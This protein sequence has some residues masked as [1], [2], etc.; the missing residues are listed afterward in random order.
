LYRITLLTPDTRVTPD[1][2]VTPDAGVTPDTHVTPPDT[3]RTWGDI[4]GSSPLTR[5]SPKPPMNPKEPPYKLKLPLCPHDAIVELFHESLP[6]L[7]RVRLMEGKRKTAIK[8]FWTWVL[9]SRKSDGSRRAET[10]E[11]ALQWIRGYF[12]RTRSN[13]FLMGRTARSEAHSNW[14]CDLDYL[15][16]DR[17]RKQVIEKTEEVHS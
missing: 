17:G 6:E 2:C 14:K 13:D 16:T 7:P 3:Q 11:Q 9:Q 1:I 12:D 10:A 4:Q 15:L 5:M 8:S